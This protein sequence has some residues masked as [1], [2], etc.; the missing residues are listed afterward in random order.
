[1]NLS[2]RNREN[3]VQNYEY[4]NH[5]KTV[6]NLNT[7]EGKRGPYTNHTKAKKTGPRRGTP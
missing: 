2:N 3:F 4:H 6:G 5:K 1:M 7:F